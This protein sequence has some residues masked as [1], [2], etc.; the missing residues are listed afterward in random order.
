MQKIETE[1]KTNSKKNSI[2]W[3]P[4]LL[5]IGL[6]GAKGLVAGF[7]AA[8]GGYAFSSMTRSSRGKLIS[9]NGGKQA[10]AV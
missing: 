3:R 6:H 4:I 2:N 9:I 7:A 10:S 1:T 8:A 5:D